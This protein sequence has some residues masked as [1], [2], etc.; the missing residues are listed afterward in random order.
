MKFKTTFII[1][2]FQAVLC[3][4]SN[5]IEPTKA[6]DL[7]AH[8]QTKSDVNQDGEITP[9]KR[10]QKEVVPGRGMTWIDD[11]RLV[12]LGAKKKTDKQLGLYLWDT[13]NSPQLIFPSADKVCFDGK[14]L[15]V[16]SHEKDRRGRYLLSGPDF[17]QADLIKP[18]RS[19]P[20]TYSN[21]Y[22]C[23]YKTIPQSLLG[24]FWKYLLPGDGYLDFGLPDQVDQNKG[25]PVE[26][27]LED[28]ITRLPT[29]LT[30][31]KNITPVVNYISHLQKYFIYQGALNL[32]E[33]QSWRKGEKLSCWFLDISGKSEEV[34]IPSGPWTI[35]SGSILLRPVCS[36]IVVINHGF[37]RDG[38]VGDSGAYLVYPDGNY[39]KLE[40]GFIGE[41][42]VSPSGCHLAF[43]H[44]TSFR[45]DRERIL[46]VI[47]LCKDTEKWHGYQ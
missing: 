7:T 43:A 32:S 30:L 1:F 13:I 16:Y 5:D 36:G 12:F 4:C 9:I 35:G 40:S 45:Y 3:S 46:T 29:G 37:A 27:I 17:S 38:S 33:R 8:S 14:Q 34:L 20:P 11:H 6:I 26:R 47:D 44:Q 28:G 15:I 42:V 21:T 10:I 19:V 23:E 39:T 41:P 31:F 18:E 2:I 25:T 24:H 22:L